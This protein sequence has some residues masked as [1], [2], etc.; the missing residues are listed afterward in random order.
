MTRASRAFLREQFLHQWTLCHLGRL[1]SN[2]QRKTS[3]RDGS[4]S[5]KGDKGKKS[6]SATWG[7]PRSGGRWEAE[8]DSAFRALFLSNL[9]IS[10]ERT[11]A[12]GT[13]DSAMATPNFSANPMRRPLTSIWLPAPKGN[14]LPRILQKKQAHLRRLFTSWLWRT[15]YRPQWF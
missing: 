14:T 6:S 1:A 7:L 2:D 3:E 13:E 8:E 12:S 11:S 9:R 10:S 4:E 5:R 15:T